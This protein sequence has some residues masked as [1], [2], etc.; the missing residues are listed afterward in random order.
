M[1]S[2]SK[3]V[4][5]FA[6]VGIIFLSSCAGSYYVTDQPV[7]PVY[8]RPVSPFAGAIWIDGDWGWSG[9]RYT[10]HR[11]Y[12]DKPRPGRTYQHGSWSHDGHGYRWNR[13]GWRR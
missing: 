3:S 7:E 13:G 5:F 11:G 6:A 4:V 9:G 2:L 1:K 8:D 10:Y 12:W